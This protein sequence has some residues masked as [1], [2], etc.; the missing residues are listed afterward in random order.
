MECRSAMLENNKIL[1]GDFRSGDIVDTTLKIAPFTRNSTLGDFEGAETIFVRCH[2][3]LVHFL[4]GK[5]KKMNNNSHKPYCK[6]SRWVNPLMMFFLLSCPKRKNQREGQ[7]L[8]KNGWRSLRSAKT[9]EIHIISTYWKQANICFLTPRYDI[10]LTPF[11]LRPPFSY[12]AHLFG[13]N[14]F[15]S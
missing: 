14:A 4:L 2:F 10:S 9:N 12:G 13:Q 6:M 15:W 11:F 3:F 1:Q 5:Q 8:R 7:G